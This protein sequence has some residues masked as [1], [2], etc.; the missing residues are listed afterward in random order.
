[1]VRAEGERIM[2]ITIDQAAD[3]KRRMDAIINELIDLASVTGK[4]TTT[5]AALTAARNSAQTARDHWDRI[6]H[7]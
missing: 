2:A 3:R 5:Y 7:D 6:L 1:M 4:Q